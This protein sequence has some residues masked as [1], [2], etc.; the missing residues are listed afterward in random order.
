MAGVPS[1]DFVISPL[2]EALVEQ[3]VHASFG[4]PP[5]RVVIPQIRIIFGVDEDLRPKVCFPQECC[6][7]CIANVGDH[8]PSQRA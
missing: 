5:V 6:T 7:R 2:S 3:R 1:T 8:L 4:E